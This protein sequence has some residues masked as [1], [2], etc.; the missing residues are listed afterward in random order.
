MSNTWKTSRSRKKSKHLV[1]GLG[2]VGRAIHAVLDDRFDVSD[3]DMG[4]DM[5]EKFDV[6]HI[7]FPYSKLFA[8]FVEMYVDKYLNQ[9]GL[10]II[11][12]S[13]P[14]GTTMSLGYK[15]IHSP[16]RGVHPDL[17]KGIRTFTKYFGGIEADTASWFFKDVGIETY[18]SYDPNEIE[19]LKLWSTTYYG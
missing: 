17:E 12:S 7:C 14:V 18:I 6:I 19:A 10:C 4:A 15:Y 3:I 1:I 9:S 5:D 13:V 2:E 8:R 11:H 16:V